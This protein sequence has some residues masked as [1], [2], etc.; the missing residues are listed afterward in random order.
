[1]SFNTLVL[2]LLL[3]IVVL[4]V[5]ILKR[6]GGFRL[7]LTSTP[8]FSDEE[9]LEQAREII[10]PYDKVSASLLQR[11]LAIGYSRAARLLDQLEEEGLLSEAVG[12]QPRTVLA[13]RSN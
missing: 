6:L 10:M 11:K 12:G 7:P 9:M 4:Q 8:G 3:V 2:L 5:L 13:R 1:M